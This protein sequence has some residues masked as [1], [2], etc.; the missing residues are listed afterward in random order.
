[1]IFPG[2]SLSHIESGQE[3][4]LDGTYDDLAP[5]NHVL[6]SYS[7]S[8]SLGSLDN[9]ELASGGGFEPEVP[10]GRISGIVRAFLVRTSSSIIAIDE[11]A[12]QFFASQLSFNCLSYYS[13]EPLDLDKLSCFC[14]SDGG[15]VVHLRILQTKCGEFLRR[16]GSRFL[17]FG[18]CM[19]FDCLCTR[20][21]T[22]SWAISSEHRFVD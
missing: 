20:F 18:L 11:S 16:G 15:Y 3:L 7:C 10:D 14:S 9:F 12:A 5:L 4:E 22:C 1:M 17:T 8:H 13:Q 2:R 19:D 21:P 6:L